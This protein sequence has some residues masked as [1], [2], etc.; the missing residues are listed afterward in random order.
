MFPAVR[1]VVRSP[2]NPVESTQKNVLA[3]PGSGDEI[4]YALALAPH[5]TDPAAFRDSTSVTAFAIAVSSSNR[6][7][8]VSPVQASIVPP[9]YVL[10]LLS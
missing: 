8:A 5:T 4:A 6:L 10:L 2:L 7:A 3:V 1:F 9:A